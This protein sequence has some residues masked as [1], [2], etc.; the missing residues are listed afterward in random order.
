MNINF[1]YELLFSF[2]NYR[3][4]HGIPSKLDIIESVSRTLTRHVYPDGWD[5]K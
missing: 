1:N 2:L 3:K 5:W 4:I